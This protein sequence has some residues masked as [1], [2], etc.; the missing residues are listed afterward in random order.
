MNKFKEQM[1]LTVPWLKKHLSTKKSLDQIVGALTNIGLEV[2]DVIKSDANLKLFKV[3]KII[4]TEK[5]P[6][7]DKLKICDVD[8]NG[9]LEKVV[10]IM[11]LN[12]LPFF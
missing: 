6:N 9:N 8:V 4:K 3:V 1:K 7:A 5:H 10:C 11:Y 2:E 12:L